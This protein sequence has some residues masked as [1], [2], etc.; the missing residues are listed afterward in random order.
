MADVDNFLY[1][2]APTVFSSGPQLK[3]AISFVIG[4]HELSQILGKNEWFSE[5]HLEKTIVQILY[6]FG[7]DPR[8][9]DPPT[10]FLLP[11]WPLI[12]LVSCT[13]IINFFFR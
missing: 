7:F 2:I 1:K 10:N 4:A 11:W 13:L 5:E 3:Y 12:L 6:Q 8:K 9:D